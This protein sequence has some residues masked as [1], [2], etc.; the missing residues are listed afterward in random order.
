MFVRVSGWDLNFHDGEVGVWRVNAYPWDVDENPIGL[1]SFWVDVV[2]S[3]AEV[4]YLKLGRLDNDFVTDNDFWIDLDWF[5]LNYPYPV[6]SV[7]RKLVSLPMW[8][9]LNDKEIK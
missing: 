4:A 2:L 1:R 6:D 7:L 5:M 3:D 9:E 8:V